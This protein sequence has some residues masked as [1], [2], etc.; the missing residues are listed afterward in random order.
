VTANEVFKDDITDTVTCQWFILFPFIMTDL[1]FDDSAKKHMMAIIIT[2]VIFAAIYFQESFGSSHTSIIGQDDD[3]PG[4][5]TWGVTR[6]ITKK[7]PPS[8]KGK[9]IIKLIH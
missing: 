8:S 2:I 9:F 7:P 4:C 5:S 1:S 3:S 6:V